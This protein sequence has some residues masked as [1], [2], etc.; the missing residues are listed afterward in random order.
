M[1]IG[2]YTITENTVVTYL[3]LS[4][5]LDLARN[6]EPGPRFPCKATSAREREALSQA[7]KLSRDKVSP[8][9]FIHPSSGNGLLF[10]LMITGCAGVCPSEHHT[11][12]YK[13]WIHPGE[14]TS[15][16]ESTH[17][18]YIRIYCLQSADRSFKDFNQPNMTDFGLW[19][20]TGVP[21]EKQWS[22]VSNVGMQL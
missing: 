9:Y 6:Y 1:Y 8:I 5:F 12:S 21:G 4:W 16:S 17:H 2:H 22:S 14:A 11:R 10:L 3:L 19:D 13:A 15:Q 18:S 7:K 20:G